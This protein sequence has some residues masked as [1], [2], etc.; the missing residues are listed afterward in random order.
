MQKI[1]D[2]SEKYLAPMQKNLTHAQ[3]INPSKSIFDSYNPRKYYDPPEM[4]T[5]EKH[6]LTHVT[7]AT[8]I[9]IQPT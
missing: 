7:H 3:K 4:F 2:A 5:H 8:H 6:F 9:R 1:L